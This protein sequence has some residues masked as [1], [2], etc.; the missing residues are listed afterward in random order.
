MLK[1]LQ[2]ITGLFL[3]FGS[4]STAQNISSKPWTSACDSVL[5]KQLSNKNLTFKG[6]LELYSEADIPS[7]G[8]S[9]LHISEN[10][11]RL[12]SISDFSAGKSF[13]DSLRAKW[14]I[15]E[16]TFSSSM[17]LLSVNQVNSGQILGPD[18]IPFSEIE[19]I[20]P[21]DSGFYISADNKR[22]KGDH[23]YPLIIN[24]P[25]PN[26]SIPVGPDPIKILGFEKH[27]KQGIEAMT[28]IRDSLLFLIHENNPNREY[29][30]AWIIN[31]KSGKTQQKLYVAKFG[32]IK[33]LST[34]KNGNILVLEKLYQTGITTV[35]ISILNQTELT[36]D[37][38]RS[39]SIL[40]VTSSCLDNFEG[41]ACFERNG[42]E[43]FMIV[44]DNNGDWQKPGRQK[45]LLLLF[46]LRPKK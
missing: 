27:S 20:A 25:E 43:Y 6:G 30:Y 26:A 42:K 33:G 18:Q 45:T 35:D 8:F 36:E 28:T 4:G 23:I 24:T 16:P 14:F 9:G 39:K 15:F 19:S 10:G 22:G 31:S 34:L 41:I 21:S 40:R 13:T 3:L 46:E 12:L 17:K 37:S 11:N 38:I 5:I 44:S 7:G 32:E 29:R 2:I 1:T